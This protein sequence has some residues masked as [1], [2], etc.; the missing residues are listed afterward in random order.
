MSGLLKISE[1]TVLAIHALIVI[2]AK[3]GALATNA[4]IAESLGA[5]GNHLSK[6]LQRLVK[7]RI[8]RSVRGPGGGFVLER[9]ASSITLR[10]VY[11]L[12]DGPMSASVCLLQEPMCGGGCVFGGLLGSL[13]SLV[14]NFMANTNIGDGVNKLG[15]EALTA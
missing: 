6:V 9:A 11:E 13:N 12:F 2:A 15:K 5:S 7:A 8:I 4:G 3:G 10:E 1:A 14:V